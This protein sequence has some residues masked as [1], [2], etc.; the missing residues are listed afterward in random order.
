M[1]GIGGVEM[2]WA[3]EVIGATRKEILTGKPYP[4]HEALLEKL[5]LQDQKIEVLRT[6]RVIN[7]IS[8]Y[9]ERCI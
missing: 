8:K 1:T 4:G 6:K 3:R 7:A 2:S 9:C 5:S